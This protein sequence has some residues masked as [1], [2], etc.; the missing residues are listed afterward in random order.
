MVVYD[1]GAHVGFYTLLFSRAVGPDGMVY[2]FEP[3]PDNFLF[4]KK[5][6]CLNKLE[7]AL[8]EQYIISA[9]NG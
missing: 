2:A 6:S 9:S 4:L 8:I 3:F 5:Y 1:V 7:N